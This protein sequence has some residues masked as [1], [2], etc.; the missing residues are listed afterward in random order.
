MI[1][2]I[3]PFETYRPSEI[4][5]GA[6]AN[7]MFART[8]SGF[9]WYELVSQLPVGPTYAQ[10][11]GGCVVAV[12]ND[13]ST[14]FPAGSTLVITDEPCERDYRYGEGMLSPA[15]ETSK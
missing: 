12:T 15:P 10:V 3:G 13:P 4:P 2:E 8:E 6:L 5:D 7:I 9:D 1:I 14:L 11:K